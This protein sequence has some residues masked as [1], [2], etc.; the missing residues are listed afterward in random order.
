LNLVDAAYHPV[1]LLVNGSHLLDGYLTMS[2]LSEKV[3]ARI[4]EAGP[5]TFREF[6]ESALYDPDYGYYNSER[7]KIGPAGDYYTSS[8]VHAAFGWSLATLI[9]SLLSKLPREASGLAPH[10][11]SLHGHYQ[12]LE[13]GAGTG[14]LAC[15]ILDALAAEHPELHSRIEYV[16]A[17]RS[18]AMVRCQ[19]DKLGPLADKVEWAGLTGAGY[20]NLESISGIVISNELIDAFPVHVIRVSPER[21][22][23][24]YVT[25][26]A[27][28]ASI[29]SQSRMSSE[30]EPGFAPATTP[31]L[32][33]SSG[34]LDIA[35]GPLSS[36]RIRQYVDRL[37]VPLAPGQVIE[38]N[39]SA[40][41]W[42]N[43]VGRI[44]ANGYIVT[45]DYGDIAQHLYGGD[46]RRG[47]LR[48]FH[49]HAL[50]SSVLDLVGEQDLTS[51]V[52]FT[53][54]MEYG[55]DAGLETVS[56][57]RQSAFL[58]RMGLI[59]RIARMAAETG[60]RA[61]LK[62]RLAIKNLFVPGGASDNFRV[63]VQRKI[64]P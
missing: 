37:G 42:L 23:E 49:E 48:A 59:D 44:L 56:L 30:P 29:H 55:R 25:C 33:A 27:V 39:L 11:Q 16:I 57:E 15:D 50:A 41:D 60:A 51:S 64:A 54:L 20:P 52:N 46:R 45:I 31:D 19:H 58:I 62:D 22:E 24:L 61:A 17:E 10:N 7:Q 28:D 14:Q 40:I 6:M 21:L 32:P 8:N 43:A 18:P 2:P 12:I 53:A 9:A 5:L 13:V 1:D 63:L 4:T 26:R 3:K 35:W 34:G 47:T 36:E 38:V